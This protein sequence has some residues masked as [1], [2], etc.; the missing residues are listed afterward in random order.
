VLP[1]CLSPLVPAAP[2]VPL[3]ELLG[4]PRP[5]L[6]IATQRRNDPLHQVVVSKWPKV[7][8]RSCGVELEFR[9]A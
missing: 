2:R 7:W 6:T 1:E 3:V 5:R 9:L 4:F 8:L